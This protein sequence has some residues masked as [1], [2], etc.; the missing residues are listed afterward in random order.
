MPV[1]V[2]VLAGTPASDLD[3]ND[4]DFVS[5]QGAFIIPAATVL[6]T[7]TLVNLLA[8]AGPNNPSNRRCP[9]GYLPV[10]EEFRL[11]LGTAWTGGTDLRLS[12]SSSTIDFVTI[13]AAALTLNVVYRLPQSAA[14]WGVSYASALTAMTG[15]TIENGLIIRAT[16]TF[17][18]GAAI[19]GW[20]KG[21]FRKYD[22]VNTF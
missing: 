4:D 15:G 5:F 1:G 3:K 8:P 6:G 18:V 19:S 22:S 21:Y 16:G 17:T 10:I 13:T 14:I 9:K 2:R 20:V 7:G 11:A 12:D